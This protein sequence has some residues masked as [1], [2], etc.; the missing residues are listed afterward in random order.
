M[1][2]ARCGQIRPFSRRDA[3][4]DWEALLASYTSLGLD[5]GRFWSLTIREVDVLCRG[6]RERQRVERNTL[7]EAAWLSARLTHADPKRFPKV[8]RFLIRD[9]KP[10]PRQSRDEML[11]VMRVLVARGERNPGGKSGNRQ[12]HY[13]GPPRKSR[14]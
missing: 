3:R 1:G 8:E 6:A 12:R 9:L 7:I 10:R 13:R 2:A 11:A 14:P 4:I 5:P